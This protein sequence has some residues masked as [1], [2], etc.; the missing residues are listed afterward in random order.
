MKALNK[1]V[2]QLAKNAAMQPGWVPLVILCYLALPIAGVPTSIRLFEHTFELSLELWAGVVA[3]GL[4][5]VGDALDKSFYKSLENQVSPKALRTTRNAARSALE[6]H[7]G[8]YDVAK[9]L[10][11]AAG[12]FQR[13]SIQF[14]NETAKFLRSLVLPIMVTGIG[15]AAGGRVLMGV[16]LIITA[17]LLVPLY[18]R[19][20][21]TH[22]QHL[23][24][25]VPLLKSDQ[26][27]F[28]QDLGPL[29]L[30]FWEGKLVG[31]AFL[32][33]AA[34]SANTQPQPTVATI[35]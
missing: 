30:F 34:A 24:D 4:F 9:A 14:L 32:A 33:V 6:I 18:A 29:R 17:V 22:I 11:T 27:C 5:L 25:L 26:K 21:A 28:I 10:A 12:S 13:L 31:S 8:V 7:D 35:G 2:D 15:L 19:I 23:Y 16:G 1:F 20:K 3:L